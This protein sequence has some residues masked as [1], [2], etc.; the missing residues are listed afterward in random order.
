MMKRTRRIEIVRSTIL[1]LSSMSQ[2][3]CDGIFRVLS[4]RYTSVRVSV[5]NNLADLE[6]VVARNPD[7]VFLGMEYVFAD[8]LFGTQD[9]NKIWV[10]QY[11]D[12]HGIAYTGSNRPVHMLERNKDLA[13]Q[14]VEEAGLRTS[15]F[16][17]AKMGELLTR[18]DIALP[19][20]L[21]V[22][23]RNRGGGVGIDSDSVIYD[24]EHLVH[25]IDAISTQLQTDSLVEEFLPGRE[26]SVAVLKTIDAEEFAIMPIELIAPLD[27]NNERILSDQV[28]T[29]NAESAIAITDDALRQQVATLALNVFHAL[30]A[31]DYGRIDIRLDR[32]GKANFL[33]AN[34]LPSLI[35]GY[36]SFPKACMLNIH[37]E[38]EPMII[39]IVELGLRRSQ[40]RTIKLNMLGD[41]VQN[42]ILAPT[43]V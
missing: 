14:K 26:F 1:E 41:G 27:K 30:G 25:K 22:K 29:S 7:L 16:W 43:P 33:E 8:Q 24:F 2:E 28:K 5:V 4:Q 21:F 40:S 31:R 34:L 32:F 19:Y 23:P 42:L 15:P 38:Y 39:Q 3:S 37:L 12:D 18:E 6:A 20:P 36:G 17:V 13:K 11:L 35:S 10:T 9:A